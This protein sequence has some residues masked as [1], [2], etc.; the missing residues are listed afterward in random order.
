MVDLTFSLLP[1]SNA[2]PRICTEFLQ[3]NLRISSAR[4]RLAARR[5]W[6]NLI[7]RPERRGTAWACWISRT[8]WSCPMATISPR[9]W[10]IRGASC[11]ETWRDAADPRLCRRAKAG[12]WPDGAAGRPPV[13]AAQPADSRHLPQVGTE[14]GRPDYAH[15]SA[16]HPRPFAAQRAIPT[17]TGCGPLSPS[18]WSER[19]I[20]RLRRREFPLSDPCRRVRDADGR[21]DPD[22]PKAA[23]RG[24][25]PS[26]D[27][28]CA[29]RRPGGGCIPIAVNGITRP[30]CW[31]RMAGA[32]APDVHFLHETPDILDSGGA[33]KN[34]LAVLGPGPIFTLNAD[35]VW[36][37]RPP[38]AGL[39]RRGMPDRMDALVALVPLEA[40]AVGRQGG[41]DF[42]LRCGR[43]H[44]VGQGADGLSTSA[45]RSS[46]RIASRPIPRPVFAGRGLERDDGEGRL[47]GHL[48][49][50]RWADV[51]HPARDR[52]GRGDGGP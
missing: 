34:A 15:V 23:D 49:D 2:S 13:G 29:R 25:G 47:I 14:Y 48:H 11:P 50:G 44:R 17:F 28:P 10:T 39:A 20:G 36:D 3:R 8:R 37:G 21:A 35:A 30:R 4:R 52:G 5:A 33:V 27:R 22:R 1:G 19:N 16:A 26:A 51:G 12:P 24:G 42:S 31:A 40:D 6:D 38:W 18:C 41:G 9:S 32:H 45:R 43:A 46:R 7:W